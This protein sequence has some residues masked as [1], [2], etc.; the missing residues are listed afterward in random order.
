MVPIISWPGITGHGEL[1]RPAALSPCQVW[2]SEPQTFA[3][4]ILTLIEPGHGSTTGYSRISNSLPMPVI[5]AARPVFAIG[6]LPASTAAPM[7]P[8]A[9]IFKRAQ[10]RM[11]SGGAR[12]EGRGARGEKEYPHGR[13]PRE[14]HHDHQTP[15][16]QACH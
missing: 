2:M 1:T 4:E 13:L 5:T 9:R 8:R 10:L 3:I 15:A 16:A 12:G 11:S 7:P 6:V 14:V